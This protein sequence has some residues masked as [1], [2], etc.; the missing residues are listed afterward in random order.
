MI[1]ELIPDL[2]NP[3]LRPLYDALLGRREPDF[4]EK[5][6]LFAVAGRMPQSC[7][8]LGDEL[9]HKIDVILDRARAVDPASVNACL[10]RCMLDVHLEVE[11]RMAAE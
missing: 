6:V 10:D 11:K 9:H 7:N 8:R 3:T 2:M 5:C 1:D 4:D